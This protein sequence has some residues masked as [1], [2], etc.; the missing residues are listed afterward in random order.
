MNGFN[1]HLSKKLNENSAMPTLIDFSYQLNVSIWVF[2]SGYKDPYFIVYNHHDAPKA[3]KC[4]RVLCYEA[5]VL[6]VDDMDIENWKLSD[7]I[8]SYIID[9][10]KQKQFPTIT[11]W[12][13][14]IDSYMS[15][16]DMMYDDIHKIYHTMPNYMQL[17]KGE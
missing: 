17:L 7:R 5:K 9:I 2:D 4:I 16:K 15:Y 8:V 14:S 13:Y 10:M 12:E 3:T 6:L 1:Y 11:K